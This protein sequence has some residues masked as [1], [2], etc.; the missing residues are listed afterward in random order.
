MHTITSFTSIGDWLFVGKS[1]GDIEK[2]NSNGDMIMV[3]HGHNAFE[4][5]RALTS[6]NEILIS[7][8]HGINGTIRIWN[9]NTGECT[10]IIQ[11]DGFISSLVVY[12]GSIFYSS[13]NVDKKDYTIRKWD[14]STEN[15]TLIFKG[16]TKTIWSLIIYN[17][18][19]FSC[20]NDNTIRKWN[21]NTGELM[22][23]M[24]PTHPPESG[25]Y[26]LA[27]YNGFLFSDDGGPRTP[28]LGRR[29][30]IIKW[31]PE[32]CQE[33]KNTNAHDGNIM[34]LTTFKDKLVSAS[35][36]GS[37]EAGSVK[38]WKFDEHGSLKNVYT[39]FDE[40]NPM[41]VHSHKDKLWI[42]MAD[43]SKKSIDMKAPQ[44]EAE[45]KQTLMPRNNQVLKSMSQHAQQQRRRAQ[46]T[47]KYPGITQALRAIRENPTSQYQNQQNC[48][49]NQAGPLSGGSKIKKTRKYKGRRYKIRYGSRGGKYIRIRVDGKVKKIYM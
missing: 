6:Y 49:P 3:L 9:S 1:N 30:G 12:N 13:N 31:N 26:T 37:T 48:N 2:C 24:N 15:E 25:I 22:C 47:K 29:Y 14:I 8:V 11:G 28:G 17:Q 19:L 33:I 4:S 32:T 20:S 42:G 44:T 43:G 5:V 45:I 35:E 21:A 27:L 34:S 38:G 46:L 40:S 39:L 23:I 7:G 36:G 10:Q 18:L 16:H 41:I